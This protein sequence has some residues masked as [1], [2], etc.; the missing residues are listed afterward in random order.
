MAILIGCKYLDII[1]LD[2]SEYYVIDVNGNGTPISVGTAYLY[3]LAKKNSKI[4][5]F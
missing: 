4:E 3:H 1:R 5:K 2:N